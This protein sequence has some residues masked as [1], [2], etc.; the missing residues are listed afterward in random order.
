MAYQTTSLSIHRKDDTVLSVRN[1]ECIDDTL[2]LIVVMSNPCRFKRRAQL[3]REFIQRMTH[4]PHVSLYVVELVFGAKDFQITSKHNKNHLQLRADVPLWHKENLVNIAVGTLL[5]HDWKCFAWVDADVV[6]ESPSW[7]QDTL[8]ILNGQK[9][10]VQLWSHCDDMDYSGHTMKIFQSFA[11]QYTL[12]RRYETGGVN[13]WHP[14]YA[15]AITREAYERIGGL[16]D[17]SILGSGDHNMAMAIVGHMSLN[18]KTTHGY[19]ESLMCR[20]GEFTQLRLGYVPGVI[21]HFFHGSK[22]NRQYSDR[23]KILVKHEYDPYKHIMY[24]EDGL[25]VPTEQCP[26]EL[27]DD[28][29]KYFQERNEDEK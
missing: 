21:R 9:D 15:W 13:L 2:H 29:L 8:K 22:K 11:H 25:L 20:L 14:G 10:I 23:W 19:Q 12:G 27:L 4:E 18:T 3:A 5:P 17:L 16:Y 7:V 26:K 24:R 6:F 1:N 28:I